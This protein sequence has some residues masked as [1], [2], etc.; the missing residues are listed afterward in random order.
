MLARSL[1]SI[2]Q[3]GYVAPHKKIFARA[4]VFYL[5]SRKSFSVHQWRPHG[6]ANEINCNDKNHLQQ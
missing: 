2:T 5:L 3:T 6:T 4:R 1:C